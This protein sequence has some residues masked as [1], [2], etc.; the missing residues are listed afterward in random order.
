MT[1]LLIFHVKTS[2]AYL[3]LDLPEWGLNREGGLF[4]KSGHKD[5]FVSFSVLLSYILLNEHTISQL[6]YTN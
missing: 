2:G 1:D 4:T 5:I 6:K 3:T